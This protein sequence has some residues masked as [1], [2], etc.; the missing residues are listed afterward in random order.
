MV[1]TRH[2]LSALLLESGYVEEALKVYS[3]DLGFVDSVPRGQRHPNNIWALHG[4]H[5]C[6]LKLNR[7]DEAAAIAPSLNAAKQL[8]DIKISRSC[9]CRRRVE[10]DT[11]KMSS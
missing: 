3:E 1:P 7:K 9:F 5:E 6:L 8:S 4:L 10:E 11:T 2:A